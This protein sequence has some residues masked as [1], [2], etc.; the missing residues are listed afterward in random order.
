VYVGLGNPVAVAGTVM[1][2]EKK[3]AY[4]F[5]G[6]Q[7]KERIGK[8][9]TAI[10]TN[11]QKALAGDSTALDWLYTKSGGYDTQ[12][13]GKNISD[14]YTKGKGWTL[15]E[16][17]GGTLMVAMIY[18]GGLRRATYE[19]YQDAATKLGVTVKPAG[20]S[21]NVAARLNNIET[22][23]YEPT[24][25]A[26]ILTLQKPPVTA[27]TTQQASLFGLDVGS[28]TLLASLGLI[29]LAFILRER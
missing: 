19:Y 14:Q 7:F 27:P 21:L 25:A 16:V 20:E 6:K 1:Q 5:G 2:V 3:L 15:K 22:P 26:P 23:V 28:P 29:A 4:I 12:K 10:A 17:G 8:Y 13:K 18:A 11:Y 9:A 24:N